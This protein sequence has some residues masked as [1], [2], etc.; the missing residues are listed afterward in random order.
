[1]M[2]YVALA[3]A[4]LMIFSLLSYT[5]YSD[6]R[7]LERIKVEIKDVTIRQI[8][9][10]MVLGISIKFIN[11][12]GREIRNMGGDIDVYILD[13]WVGKLN[14]SGV[15]IDGH[16]YQEIEIPLTLYYEHLTKSIV[17]AINEMN[18]NLSIKGIIKGKVLFGLVDYK[19]PVMAK[20]E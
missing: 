17:Q 5:F 1:M 19:V 6:V 12:E 14:F 2:K 20:W 9:P 8:L 16:S 10:D 7:A 11:E 4:S 13:K 15:N 18:F 3:A